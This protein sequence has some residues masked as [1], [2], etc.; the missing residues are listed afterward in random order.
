[1]IA[2]FHKQFSRRRQQAFAALRFAFRGRF[3]RF[4]VQGDVCAHNTKV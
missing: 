4:T 3:G 2:A 1:V